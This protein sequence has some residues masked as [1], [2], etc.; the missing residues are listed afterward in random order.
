M[1]EI[2]R[3]T[4]P[5]P[6]SLAET[7]K[8]LQKAADAHSYDLHIHY[9]RMQEEF[10][11]LWMILR[12][13]VH[14]DRMP[15]GEIRIETWL[16]KPGALVSIRDYSIF[17]GEKEIGYGF[18]SWSLVSEAQR[19]L[20][21]LRTVDPVLNAPTRIPERTE[22]LKRIPLPKDLEE[23]GIWTVLPQDIDRN[24]HVNNVR[25]IHH[26]EALCPNCTDLEVIY[27]R[28]CFV[29][30]KIALL[31]KDGYVQGVKESGEECFRAKFWRD[32]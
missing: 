27:D 19:R 22:V 11:Y 14:L 25:Y 26:S 6:G 32:L 9:D 17:E 15:Q 3:I 29:G 5:A 12:G 1:E 4:A 2:Y 30:E 8:L 10:Q 13:R 28:E 24:G 23:A 18:H 31:A 16:R 7:M 20:V 21:N